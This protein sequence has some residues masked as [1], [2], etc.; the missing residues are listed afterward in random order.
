MGQSNLGGFCFRKTLFDIGV[1][2]TSPRFVKDR[3]QVV[4][5][6]RPAGITGTVITGTDLQEL[7]EACE[8]AQRYAGYCWSTAGLHPHYASG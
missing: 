8:L 3:Q 7:L 4:T 1:N 2:L 6:A 5:R